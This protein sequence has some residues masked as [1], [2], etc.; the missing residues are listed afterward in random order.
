MNCPLIFVIDFDVRMGFE[1]SL[2][3]TCLSFLPDSTSL[4]RSDQS[5]LLRGRI[6]S[7]SSVA[8]CFSE[9]GFF[10]KSGGGA[11]PGLWMRFKRFL[12]IIIWRFCKRD[13]SVD[14][15]CTY[16]GGGGGGIEFGGMGGGGGPAAK[17]MT[18]NLDFVTYSKQ[19]FVI[20]LRKKILL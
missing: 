17:N 9:M 10:A 18:K 7:F 5:G 4:Q 13:V 1:R 12:N 2:V 20:F 14:R 8:L 11:R 16:G 19:A 6:F 3:S 15:V